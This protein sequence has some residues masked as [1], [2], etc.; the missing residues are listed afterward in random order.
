ML[1]LEMTRMR[2]SLRDP[3]NVLIVL[4][5][6]AMLTLGDSYVVERR[7][8]A[9]VRLLQ[10]RDD[11]LQYVAMADRGPSAAMAPYRYRVLTPWLA[12][13][14]SGT[15]A[16]GLWWITQAS[17]LLVFAIGLSLCRRAGI[18]WTGAGLGLFTMAGFPAHAYHFHNPYLTDA[19][20]LAVLTALLAAAWTQRFALFFALALVAPLVRE[21]ACCLLPMWLPRSVRRGMLALLAG[22]GV[23]VVVHLLLA[24]ASS[25]GEA[26]AAYRLPPMR[27]WLTSSLLAWSFGW[28]L[29]AIGVLLLRWNAFRT[30][31]LAGLLLAGGAFAATFVASD[32][33]RMFGLL[34]PVMLIGCARAFDVSLKY[35]RALTLLLIALAIAQFLCVVPNPFVPYDTWGHLGYWPPKLLL[36]AGTCGAAALAWR[37]RRRLRREVWCKWRRAAASVRQRT[38]RRAEHDSG[39]VQ[40]A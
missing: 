33:E 28:W 21:T 23:L 27:A 14:W 24:P 34:T 1:T 26:A 5:P 29:A 2:V 36:A 4:L 19:A 6:V 39:P 18:G 22:L 31:M 3:R 11:N 9:T 30:V 32:I 16:D 10:L 38:V 12:S 37:L 8:G 7:P 25:P 13:H 35:N 40:I 17:L 20:G 15:A